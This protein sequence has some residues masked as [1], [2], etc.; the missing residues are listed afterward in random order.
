MT[1][2][3]RMFSLIGEQRGRQEQLAAF[4]GVG[5]TTI[6]T[7]KKRNTD[8]PAKHL[9]RICEFLGCSLE[10]LLTGEESSQKFAPEEVKGISLEGLKVGCLWDHLNEAGK[11]IVLGDIYKRLESAHESEDAGGRPLKEA[12]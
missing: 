4:L 8:P 9:V 10:Y 7:W 1:I 5:P 2:S 6:T 11:A 3:E 12:L